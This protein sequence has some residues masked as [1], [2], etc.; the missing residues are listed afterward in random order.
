MS[1][2][3]HCGQR[4][5]KR[6]CPARR[7]SLC[8]LCCGRLRNREIACPPACRHLAEHAPYQEQRILGRKADT[9]AGSKSGR[10]D[11]F[12]DERLAWLALQAEGPLHEAASQKR[13]FTDGDAVLALEY[14]K[15]KTAKGRGLLLVPGM[16]RRSG[17]E[18]GEAVFRSLENCRYERSVVLASGSEGY[19]NEE[20]IRVLE[21]LILAAKSAAGGDFE[22]RTYLDR[23]GAAFARMAG[24]ARDPKIITP[25]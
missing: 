20:K 1:K 24:D 14:A 10:D 17:N 22:G 19:T 21:R 3:A 4:K 12:E 6:S 13:D 16:E 7:E 2:C 9:P 11:V 5:A 18:V 8:P 25:P 15:D 23:L